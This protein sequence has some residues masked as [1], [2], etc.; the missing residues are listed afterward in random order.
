MLKNVVN[1]SCVRKTNLCTQFNVFM[2]G[3]LFSERLRSADDPDGDCGVA[4]V[5]TGGAR[6]VHLHLHEEVSRAT[7]E[8]RCSLELLMR[9]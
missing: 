9:F 2:Y 4:D 5:I 1:N 8:E 3:V 6:D 7:G